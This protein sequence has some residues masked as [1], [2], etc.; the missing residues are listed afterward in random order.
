MA[1]SKQMGDLVKRFS[2]GELMGSEI[3]GVLSHIE[4]CAMCSQDLDV[5]AGV[6]T[7]ARENPAAF[8]EVETSKTRARGRV[9]LF[10]NILRRLGELLGPLPLPAK[11]L[12]PVAAALFILL[13]SGP[14][15]HTQDRY[16]S[17]ADLAPSPYYPTALRGQGEADDLFARAMDEYREGDYKGASRTLGRLLEEEGYNEKADLY[18]GIS[19]LLSDEAPRAVPHL[20]RAAASTSPQIREKALWYLAQ[21]SFLDEDPRAARDALEKVVREGGDLSEKARAQITK[22]DL[23][24]ESSEEQ[25]R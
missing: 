25:S 2:L 7:L 4:T 23:L 17:L 13:M 20:E 21:A 12:A 1:C 10:G 16:R 5:L 24:E 22:L 19:L 14:F 3:D 11:V 6:A 18:L 8:P 9:P 15:D